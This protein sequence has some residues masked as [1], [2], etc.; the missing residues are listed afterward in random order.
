MQK[1]GSSNASEID[2]IQSVL[3]DLPFVSS[4]L[5]P[6]YPHILYIVNFYGDF[7]GWSL[8]IPYKNGMTVISNWNYNVWAR[9]PLGIPQFF[10]FNTV[11]LWGHALACTKVTWNINDFVPPLSCHSGLVAPNGHGFNGKWV[12]S[13]NFRTLCALIII[14][15]AP[16]TFNIFLHLCQG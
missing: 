13:K 2:I 9:D 4:L 10:S 1:Y 8:G 15:I 14:S 12:W 11:T 16:P 7:Q 3:I 5:Q 6:S